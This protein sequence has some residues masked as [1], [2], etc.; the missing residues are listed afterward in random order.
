MKA[1]S[2][3]KEDDGLL[4][5]TGFTYEEKEIM[6]HVV[7]AWNKFIKL[8]RYHPNEASEFGIH[9]DGLQMC[10]GMR[11]LNREHP[12]IFPIKE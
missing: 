5:G 1:K 3:V 10:L 7:E 4:I 11:I 2:K 12:E 6:N 9:I 8:K